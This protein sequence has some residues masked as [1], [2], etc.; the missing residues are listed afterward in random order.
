M[1]KSRYFQTPIIKS[2]SGV[3]EE[4]ASYDVPQE[5]RGYSSLELTNGVQTFEHV[6][7]AGERLDHLAAKFFGDDQ[8]WWVIAMINS[9][10]FG[11]NIAPG[12]KL[13]IPVDVR[14]VLEKLDL[15]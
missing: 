11:L 10:S 7:S 13:L 8:Y 15:V 6:Y 5:M 12:T 1:A 4:Y 14:P 9:V 3:P 2:E